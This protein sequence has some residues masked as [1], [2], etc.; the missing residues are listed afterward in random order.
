M[1]YIMH[2][3][4]I[5][6]IK[7]ICTNEDN[8][9]TRVHY[10]TAKYCYRDSNNNGSDSSQSSSPESS[11]DLS[12]YYDKKKSIDVKK[13]A[14]RGWLL[15]DKDN[16]KLQYFFTL[17]KMHLYYYKTEVCFSSFLRFLS[18]SNMLSLL[19]HSVLPLLIN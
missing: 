16:T 7:R 3:T 15:L 13:I 11:A 8:S 18:F 12:S 6:I 1:L 19:F 5:I 17:K 2:I 4:N 9:N 14:K 10:I